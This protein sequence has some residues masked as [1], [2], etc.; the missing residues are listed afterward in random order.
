MIRDKRQAPC[1][2]V[3]QVQRCGRYALVIDFGVMVALTELVGL[4]P[5]VSTA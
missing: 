3:S 5:V 2:T 1:A 4:P